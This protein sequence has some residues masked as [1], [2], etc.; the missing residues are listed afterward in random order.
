MENKSGTVKILTLPSTQCSF[1]GESGGGDVRKKIINGEMGHMREIT[2]RCNQDYAVFI[3]II[4]MH[5]KKNTS[6]SF[7][8]EMSMKESLQVNCCC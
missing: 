5:G 3:L 1:G 8:K 2:N 7:S 6:S 4:F